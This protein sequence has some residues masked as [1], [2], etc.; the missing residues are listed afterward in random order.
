MIIEWWSLNKQHD[1]KFLSSVYMTDFGQ[2]K[3]HSFFNKKMFENKIH[4]KFLEY[5]QKN[6]Q[7]D[8]RKSDKSNTR[9]NPQSQDTTQEE[10][11]G[12][13]KVTTDLLSKF[14]DDSQLNSMISFLELWK[15]LDV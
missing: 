9:S 14:V 15:D 8:S 10:E 13:G 5:Q 3:V 12:E 2:V 7:I 11:Q 4:L 6:H 1:I